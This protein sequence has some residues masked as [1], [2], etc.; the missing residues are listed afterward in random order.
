MNLD[1]DL[2]RHIITQNKL[3]NESA[4]EIYSMLNQLQEQ[5][6]KPI[7]Q[8]NAGW[9]KYQREVWYKTYYTPERRAEISAQSKR[10]PR[11]N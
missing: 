6:N 1:F 11:H 5:I 3:L 4:H 8:T 2:V 9:T 7:K 10:K